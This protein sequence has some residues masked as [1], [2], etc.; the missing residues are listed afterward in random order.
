MSQYDTIAVVVEEES[1][2][3]TAI[4]KGSS[5][6]KRGSSKD[7][8]DQVT[9]TS[10]NDDLNGELEELDMATYGQYN[11]KSIV[12]LLIPFALFTLAF[13]GNVAPKISII[14]QLV[15]REYYAK[16]Q[17]NDLDLNIS[18]LVTN[19]IFRTL[20]VDTGY[21]GSSQTCQVASVFEKAST[22]NLWVGLITGLVGSFT[23]PR[24]GALSDRFGR[25]P[26]MAIGILGPFVSD[27]ITIAAAK[28]PNLRSYRFFYLV[29]LADGATGS[30]LMLMAMCHSYA[31][32]CTTPDKRA[33]AFGMFHG[34][35]FAGLAIGPTLSGLLISKTGN[36]L[37]YFYVGLFMQI[38]F[39][40][41]VIFVVPESLSR[42]EREKAKKLYRRQ[43]LLEA[44]NSSSTTSVFGFSAML[45]AVNF[46]EPLK[47]FWPND[48]TRLIL[49][50]NLALL[51]IMDTLAVG[52]SLAEMM[53]VLMYSE[54]TFDWDSVE[55]GRYVTVIGICRTILLFLVLPNVVEY[56][57]NYVK[58]L[59]IRNSTYI[60][61][62]EISGANDVDIILIRGSAIIGMTAYLGFFLS[63]SPS[64]FLMCGALSAF[65]GGLAPT[66][67]SCISKHVPSLKTGNILGAVALSHSIAR[68]VA[69]TAYLGIYS[70]TVSVYPKTLFLVFIS[71][72]LLVFIS[73]FFI[74]R[75]ITGGIIEIND[76]NALNA[77]DSLISENFISD[78]LE[79]DHSEI[80]LS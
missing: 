19:S 25:R 10:Y 39:A 24:F 77:G 26:I 47:A 17:Q 63:N 72:F 30:F 59:Q 43:K 3:G 55:S 50:K 16:T 70:L 32:D 31:S 12:W 11:K 64:H 18:D 15:C 35:L 28:S 23:A 33:A 51:G 67:E 54:Y 1:E 80:R 38:L 40:L 41:L 78:S 13:G 36:I 20:G 4:I 34:V 21:H 7:P 44:S 66:L 2:I 57:K 74:V 22:I 49:K 48:G 61:D 6:P 58:R 37:S 62:E 5:R 8:S 68:V 27:L 46:F 69:P 71:S 45:K 52:N 29:A 56:L 73:S 75:N 60:P 65:A 79:I 42:K 14:V 76:N 9:V 53:A